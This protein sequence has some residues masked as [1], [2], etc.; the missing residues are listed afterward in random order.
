MQ[1]LKI[2]NSKGQIRADG[3]IY[4]VPLWITK[5]R[6]YGKTTQEKAISR[7]RPILVTGAHD[8]G[9][10][11]FLMRL[12]Q[13]ALSVWTVKSEPLWL[14]ALRPLVAWCDTPQVMEWW[15]ALR[16]IEEEKAE[17]GETLKPRIQWRSLK[18]WEKAEVLPD[19]LRDTNAILFI[20]DAHRLSGRKLQI[21]RECAL[22][23]KIHVISVSEEQRLPPN[24]RT[25]LMRRDPQIY[26]LDSEASYDATSIIMWFFVLACLGAGFWEAGAVVG[27]LQALS[28][29]RRASRAD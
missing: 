28:G 11:R 17:Q 7:K 15:E 9:K 23:S 13:Q 19:Y 4:A 26:R 10:T 18:Q 20:D 16:K 21:A 25:V 22:A 24:L 12:H 5:N 27:G 29:G 14:G 1:F 3:S 8:S 2:K 6:K